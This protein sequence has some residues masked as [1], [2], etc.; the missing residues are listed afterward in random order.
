M[1][2]YTHY[3]S[4]VSHEQFERI[5]PELEAIRMKTKP[6]KVDL[7]DVFCA[8]LYVL[9]SGC[10]WRLLPKDFP[11]WRTV[12]GYWQL[13]KHETNNGLSLLDQVLKKIGWRHSPQT[14]A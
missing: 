9:R 7:Y 10:Q 13:W 1:N 6:R 3:P 11:N 5:R 14:Q 4:D 12:Y 2:T 8:M